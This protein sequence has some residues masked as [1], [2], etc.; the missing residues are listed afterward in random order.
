[1]HLQDT[2]EA[3]EGEQQRVCAAHAKGNVHGSSGCQSTC[4]DEAISTFQMLT[5]SMY[6][7]RALQAAEKLQ[8]GSLQSSA[9][10][11]AY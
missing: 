5:W 10:A 2:V 4:R 11:Q 6:C 9:L 7:Q 1:M 3:P 8:M